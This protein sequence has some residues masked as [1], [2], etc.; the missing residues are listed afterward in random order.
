MIVW[1]ELRDRIPYDPDC[2]L[3]ESGNSA[4]VFL[5]RC[6]LIGKVGRTV[7][8]ELLEK[9]MSDVGEEYRLIMCPDVQ[10]VSI[11]DQSLTVD[12]ALIVPSSKI[13]LALIDVDLCELTVS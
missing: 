3:I 6:R 13:D 2:Q 7:R 9:D 11:A 5:Q 12:P 8:D 4:D 1:T 10:S